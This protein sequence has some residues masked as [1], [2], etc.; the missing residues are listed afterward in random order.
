MG[1]VDIDRTVVNLVVISV[2][3]VVIVFF[4]VVDVLIHIQNL[5]LATMGI[6]SCSDT[7]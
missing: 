2:V 6:N 3:V 4:V 1:N 7:C 5:N